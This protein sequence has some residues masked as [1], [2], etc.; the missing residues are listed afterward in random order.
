[1]GG[2]SDRLLGMMH[3]N[4]SVFCDNM[5]SM[6]WISVRTE[7]LI[8]HQCASPSSN[9]PRM[10]SED[11]MKMTLTNSEPMR[12]NQERAERAVHV[13]CIRMQE[14][15]FVTQQRASRPSEQCNEREL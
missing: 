6:D 11:S 9:D 15:S 2:G 1:M 10:T 3:A 7:I 14:F 13:S 5:D 4:R 12:T 8:L